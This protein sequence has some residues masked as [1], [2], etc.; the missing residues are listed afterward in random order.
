M[1]FGFIRLIEPIGFK[2]LEFSNS[3]AD[4]P[5]ILKRQVLSLHAF[6]LP[7]P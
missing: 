6:Q 2:C 7:K 3:Q 5:E 1:E 4:C